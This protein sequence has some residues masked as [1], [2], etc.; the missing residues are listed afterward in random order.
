MVAF[1]GLLCWMTKFT[2]LHDVFSIPHRGQSTQGKGDASVKHGH[3]KHDAETGH[4]T[5]AE[6]QRERNVLEGI[7]GQEGALDETKVATPPCKNS[8]CHCDIITALG[9]GCPPRTF[10][11]RYHLSFPLLLPN[12]ACLSRS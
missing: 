12:L 4:V 5:P 8:Q 9:H 1:F 7:L 3:Q 2:S 10:S 11:L 6:K